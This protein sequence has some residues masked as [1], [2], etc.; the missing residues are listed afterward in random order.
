MMLSCIE[1]GR[2][3]RLPRIAMLGVSHNTKALNQGSRM[4]AFG[5]PT[6]GSQLRAPIHNLLLD[7]E[8]L[9]KVRPCQT[10]LRGVL[11]W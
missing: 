10:C 11:L 8:E 1:V 9:F 6:R 4:E 5:L 7:I 2:I 3:T